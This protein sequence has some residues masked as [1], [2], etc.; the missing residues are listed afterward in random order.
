[1]RVY[2]EDPE[3]VVTELN[4]LGPGDYFGE[5]A[6]VTGLPRSATVQTL[7]ETILRQISKPEFDW[8]LD[9]NPQLPREIIRQLSHRLA[10]GDILLTQVKKQEIKRRQISW[11]DYLVILGLGLILGLGFNGFNEDSIPLVYGWVKG[12]RA[13][14]GALATVSPEQARQAYQ[15]GQALFVDAQKK[16]FYNKLHL[17]DALPLPPLTFNLWYAMLWDDVK[18]GRNLDENFPIIVYGGNISRPY[19]QEVARLL[20]RQG[21]TRVSVLGGGHHAWKTEFPLESA[22]PAPLPELPQGPLTLIEWLPLGIFLIILVPPLWRS[23]YL[24]MGCRVI[25][26]IIFVSFT[27]SKLIRPAVFVQNII[28]YQMMPAWGVNL[29]ALSLPGVELVAGLFLILGIRA[30]ASATLIG[31]LNLLF[32][33]GLTYALL[34]GVPINC[35]CYGEVGEPVTWWKVAKN[36]GMLVMSLQILLYDR[37]FVLDRGG[38][39]WR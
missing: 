28:D 37:L 22:N 39:V 2:D 24:S 4:E 30:R 13:Q 26:G 36:V 20:I 9:H 14:P 16:N 23:P 10:Q 17:K 31:G 33:A 7:E 11:F 3:G 6:M 19:D 15:N 35:G 29:F 12:S 5:M 38:F 1:V 32:I 25:L 8:L 21:H 34:Q 27:L 18:A